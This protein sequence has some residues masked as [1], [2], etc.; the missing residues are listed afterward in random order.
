MSI[1][2]II[3]MWVCYTPILF[4]CINFIAEKSIEKNNLAY[5]LLIPLILFTVGMTEIKRT[6]AKPQKEKYEKVTETFYR[7]VK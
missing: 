1:E 5:L 2:G 6:D 7:K 3:L 4:I